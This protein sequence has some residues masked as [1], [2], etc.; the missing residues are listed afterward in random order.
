MRL[1][2]IGGHCLSTG[3]KWGGNYLVYNEQLS[4]MI[5]DHWISDHWD[6]LAIGSTTERRGTAA[7]RIRAKESAIKEGQGE[8]SKR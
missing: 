7:K 8:R 4:T 6:C 2:S 5:N 3:W 1:Y